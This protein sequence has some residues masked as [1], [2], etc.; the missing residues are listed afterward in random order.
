[1]HYVDRGIEPTKLKAVRSK[2]GLKW[3]KYYEKGEGLKPS[4][5]A[6]QRFRDILGQRFS[7]LCGYCEEECRG[8][9]DHFRPKTTFPRLVYEWSNW[10]FACNSCN[11]YKREKWPP[12][13]YVN[14]CLKNPSPESRFVFDT[15]TGEIRPRKK[16]SKAEFT[17]AIQTIDDLRL[18]A[19]YHLKK[20]KRWLY[21]VRIAL[22]SHGLSQQERDQIVS[23]WTAPQTA[24]SSFTRE[25]MRELKLK[26]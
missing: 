6:W 24:H 2:H 13:G 19:L 21:A 3:I 16:L 1:M 4:D 11:N 17:R 14:P 12:R 7:H 10:V 23:T 15:S 20:R 5:K 18:D 26:F 8:E 25:L 22:R 9:V